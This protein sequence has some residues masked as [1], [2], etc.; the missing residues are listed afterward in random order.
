VVDYKVGF[1]VEL[2]TRDVGLPT[3]SLV[4]T[5]ELTGTV[6]QPTC[7]VFSGY[8]TLPSNAASDPMTLEF[9]SDST[10]VVTFTAQTEVGNLSDSA[11]GT[12]TSAFFGNGIFCL[13]LPI[14]ILTGLNA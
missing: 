12:W 1:G 11:S 7:Y 2:Q 10:V 3:T 4:S 14:Y 13:T 6:S 8:M 5:V 9:T